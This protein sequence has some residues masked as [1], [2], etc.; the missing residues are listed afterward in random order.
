MKQLNNKM[1]VSNMNRFHI[2][3]LPLVI[4]FLIPFFPDNTVEVVGE[5]E[6]VQTISNLD[7]IIQDE[8]IYGNLVGLAVSVVKDGKIIHQKSYGFTDLE[9]KTPL[10]IPHFS[11]G[12]QFPR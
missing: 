12:H 2:K 7:K 8:M 11:D 9:K 5:N 3:I 1:K 4:F 6:M 10:R